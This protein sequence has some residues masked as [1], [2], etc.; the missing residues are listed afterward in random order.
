MTMLLEPLA[1]GVVDLPD[2]QRRGPLLLD[3]LRSTLIVGMRACGKTTTVRTVLAALAQAGY[4]E[5]IEVLIITHTA[6]KYHDV[7]DLGLRITVAETR[8]D[9]LVERCVRRFA[10]QD[11]E[12]EDGIHTLLIIDGWASFTTR[13]EELRRGFCTE[14]VSQVLHAGASA[15]ASLIVCAQQQRE[16][17]YHVTAMFSQQLTMTLSDPE[18]YS[19]VGF[20]PSQVPPQPLPGWCIW[21]GSEARVAVAEPITAYSAPA[22]TT[23]SSDRVPHHRIPIQE[24]P[25]QLHLA[26]CSQI[27]TSPD[28]VFAIG[29]ALNAPISL[30]AGESCLIV[31]HSGSGRTTTLATLTHQS[32]PDASLDF[33]FSP[34]RSP[35]EAVHQWAGVCIG[36]DPTLTALTDLDTALRT[37]APAKMIRLV[38]D[39]FTD[40]LEEAIEERIASILQRV[41]TPPVQCLIAA[42]PLGIFSRYNAA[43]SPLRGLSNVVILEPDADAGDPLGITLPRRMLTPRKP[44]RGYYCYRGRP[45]E[46]QILIP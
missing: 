18:G 12:P 37:N 27:D 45:T 23:S 9:E 41:T 4:R 44:G 40:F 29:T 31:G 28:N 1:I 39:D 11:V 43:S 13:D 19:D 46:I 6:K 15:H 25:Q 5:S 34:R 32:P 8:Q 17:P 20:H 10:G 24:F 33:L 42:H 36:T 22:D 35:L 3:P 7:K 14:L 2:E 16:L 21:K 38:I 30:P 26:S